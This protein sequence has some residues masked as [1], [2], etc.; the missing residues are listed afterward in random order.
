MH[1]LTV[2]MLQGDSCVIEAQANSL[3]YK[4]HRLTVPMLQGSQANGSYATTDALRN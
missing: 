1:R 2:P 4:D 3:C